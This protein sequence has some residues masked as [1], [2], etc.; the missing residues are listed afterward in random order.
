MKKYMKQI[1]LLLVFGSFIFQSCNGQKSQ[2]PAVKEKDEIPTFEEKQ[3]QALTNSGNNAE[4]NILPAFT[5]RNA[6]R[7]ATQG[8]V[9][10]KSVFSVRAG[11]EIPDFFRDFF[12]D[13]FWHHYFPRDTNK[14]RKQVS[15]ASGVIISSDGYIVT[16]N[17]VVSNE[18]NIEVVLADQRN[19][20]AKIIG[21]DPATDL[22]LLKI[23]VK[24]LSFIEFGNSDS[25]EVGDF[26]LAV[27]NPFN[28]ASTVTAGI[29]SAKARNINL[30]S[31][32]GAV[33]S[34]IQTDAAMNPGNSGG[35]LVDINGK[36]I[37]IT[38]AIA[39]PT[40]AYAGYSFAI[41]VDIVRKTADD[42]LR[43]GKAMHGYLGIVMSDMN[44]DKAKLLGISTTTGVI[45]DS[46]ESNSAAGKAGIKKNDIIIKINDR[47]V[48]TSP[49]LQEIIATYKPGEIL[50]LTLIRGREVKTMPVALTSGEE[51]RA[52]SLSKNKILKVLGIEI[53]ALSPA[54]KYKLKLS[55]GIKVTSIAEGKIAA[56]TSMENGFIII[57]VNR[58]TINTT[59]EF[60]RALESAKGGV[61]LE[62]IYPNLPGIYYYAIGL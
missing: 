12:G 18:E 25:V 34:Y 20:K 62:G 59:G 38:S 5:F 30:L 26:V 36:L 23:D 17:H 44:G 4:H 7:K 57:R 2:S 6:A 43:Y 48:E 24:N 52:V 49:Q 9:H 14:F 15:S 1:C 41:P 53:A 58:T 45:V 22:A 40:G 28:L 19:Y 54:E 13:D 55:G 35:A 51:T 11:Q 10:I 56:E 29:V 46:L 27:G 37:G 16:N 50:R 47:K 3:K 33:E 42:L 61:M 39:S 8:V 21:T 60:I 32:R 31:D